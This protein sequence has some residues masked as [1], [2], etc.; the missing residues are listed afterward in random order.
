MIPRKC[1][2]VNCSIPSQVSWGVD[3][4]WFIEQPK[5]KYFDLSVVDYYHQFRN[6]SIITTT[7]CAK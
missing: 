7:V 6:K 2:V 5:K 1:Q 3:V 4:Q